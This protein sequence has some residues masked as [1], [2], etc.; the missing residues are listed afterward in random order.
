MAAAL[1]VFGLCVAVCLLAHVAIL[2]SVLRGGGGTRSLDVDAGVRRP[3]PFVEIV[4]A[5]LP[6]LALALVLI[7]TWPRV[8]SHDSAP[9]AQ[10]RVAR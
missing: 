5:V 3:T 8:R 4:W 1:T 6:A 2:R 10:G 9:P 7:A